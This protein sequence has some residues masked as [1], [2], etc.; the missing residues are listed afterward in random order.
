MVS[1]ET[2]VFNFDDVSLPVLG[3]FA[4]QLCFR[5]HTLSNQCLFCEVMEIYSY[6]VMSFIVL[7]FASDS[8][9]HFD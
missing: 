8:S 5:C 1:F 2:W 9:T 6:K 7:V 4:F 3:S